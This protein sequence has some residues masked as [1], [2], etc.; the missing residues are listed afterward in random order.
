MNRKMTEIEATSVEEAIKIGLEKL[1]TTIENIDIEILEEPKSRFLNIGS[2][3]AKV[4]LIMINSPEEDNIIENDKTKKEIL[5]T[6][7]K[8]LEYMGFSVTPEISEFNNKYRIII[9]DTEDANLLIGKSGKTIDALQTIIN[10]IFSKKGTH[11]QIFLDIKGYV[12]QKHKNK[13]Q[14]QW[15]QEKPYSHK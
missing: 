5:E 4:R 6:F 13:S 7:N 10:R 14:K 3:K 9:K 2:K 15:K 12:I 8:L 1:N 11:K